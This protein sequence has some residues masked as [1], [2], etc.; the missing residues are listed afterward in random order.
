MFENLYV[1]A[2]RGLIDAA[3]N[4]D[5]Q[6]LRPPR[7]LGQITVGMTLAATLVYLATAD[8]TVV[9]TVVNSAIEL[10][11]SHVADN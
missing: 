6:W 8:T 4:M 9:D 7:E 1:I 5:V 3:R 2:E 10:L 11:M